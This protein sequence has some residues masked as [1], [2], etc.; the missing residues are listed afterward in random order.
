[1]LSHRAEAITS[2]RASRPVGD[3]ST[4]MDPPGVQRCATCKVYEFLV[5]GTKEGPCYPQTTGK[6][7]GRSR[8]SV[9]WVR[10]PA[11]PKQP[12]RLTDD[13]RNDDLS[14]RS[15]VGLRSSYQAEKQRRQ[16]WMTRSHCRISHPNQNLHFLVAPLRCKLIASGYLDKIHEEPA[17][18]PATC[19]TL[20]ISA[21]I[22]PRRRIHPRLLHRTIS[23]RPARAGGSAAWHPRL[24]P[25]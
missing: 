7:A 10:R 5:A 8:S 17:A 1:M 13:C 18:P 21:R 19:S 23:L 11:A 15:V 14:C 6:I 22:L 25:V 24:T 20:A 3:K 4:T 16:L 12:S 9:G 2:S